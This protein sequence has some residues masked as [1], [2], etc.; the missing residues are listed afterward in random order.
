MRKNEICASLSLDT[1]L[2]SYGI[3]SAKRRSRYPG[4]TSSI[5]APAYFSGCGYE[6]C[7]TGSNAPPMHY[8]I[9]Q[10][11]APC[12]HVSLGLLPAL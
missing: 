12:T 4:V 2:H 3:G 9:T 1:H 5:I 10:N 8:Q 6:T 11:V 7:N